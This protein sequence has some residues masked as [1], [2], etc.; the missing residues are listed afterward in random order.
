M[1][2]KPPRLHSAAEDSSNRVCGEHTL[3]VLLEG[4]VIGTVDANDIYDDGG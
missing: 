1:A 2:T 3:Q 4:F